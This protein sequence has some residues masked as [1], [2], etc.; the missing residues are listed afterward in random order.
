ARYLPAASEAEVGGDWYDAVPVSAGRV[1]LVMG[2][3]SGKGLAAASTLGALRHAIR[4]Y[5]L[6]GH[7]PAEIAERL[8]RFVLSDPAREHMAT[9]VL[10]VFD[11]VTARL[12]WVNA[13]HPPALALDG[14][15]T[16][17]LLERGRSV[18]LG[19][20]AFP[21][22]EEEN[23][24]LD[25]GGAVILYTDGLIERRGEHLDD[26][27]DLLARAASQGSL[28]PDAL[29]ERLLDAAVPAAGTSDD[30]ALLVLRHIPL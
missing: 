7:G 10:A 8:N 2:D 11:P 19:V 14:D 21:G 16:P 30:V 23:A 9:L 27:F 17:H 22:Y 15:G 4:A 24:M 6:E 25:P 5:A 28:D 20:M 29:C 13:G 26:G 18:P 1:L 3:V 12:T